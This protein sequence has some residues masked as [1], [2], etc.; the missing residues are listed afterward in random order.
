[1]GGYAAIAKQAAKK[2]EKIP[3]NKYAEIASEPH[4]GGSVASMKKGGKV[5]RTGLHKLHKGEQ[6][7]KQSTAKRYRKARGKE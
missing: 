1:M 2:L 6:V 4:D 3:E 7:L 5:K